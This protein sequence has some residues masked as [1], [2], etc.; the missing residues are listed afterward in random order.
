MAFV[1]FRL[2]ELHSLEYR[3]DA[4]LFTDQEQRHM[5]QMQLHQS[6]QENPSTLRAKSSNINGKIINNNLKPI[7]IRIQIYQC[8]R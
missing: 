7:K 2:E 3:R 8:N 4:D 5:S 1:N 6:H